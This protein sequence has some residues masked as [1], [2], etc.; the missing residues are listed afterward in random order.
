MGV[1][2]VVAADAS[3]K[4]IELAPASCSCDASHGGIMLLFGIAPRV[5]VDAGNWDGNMELEEAASV[6]ER[7]GWAGRKVERVSCS[8]IEAYSFI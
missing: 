5:G 1:F 2:V 6:R 8:L 7:R 4:N 3:S